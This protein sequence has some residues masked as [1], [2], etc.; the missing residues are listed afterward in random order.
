MPRLSSSNRIR[1]HNTLDREV[2][3][4]FLSPGIGNNV[5]P[6]NAK[7]P[8]ALFRPEASCMVTFVEKEGRWKPM[9]SSE[10]PHCDRQAVRRRRRN[11]P[12]KPRRA[13]VAGSGT[14]S[15]LT[16]SATTRLPGELCF[17]AAYSETL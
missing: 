10:P 7:K 17:V 13:S 8:P 12:P 2:G 5:R 11:R 4:P 9:K 1:L 6:N 16:A 14:A 3:Q 15:H